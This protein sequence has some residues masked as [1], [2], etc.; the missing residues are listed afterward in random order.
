MRGHDTTREGKARRTD[1]MTARRAL[2]IQSDCGEL[3]KSMKSRI[4]FLFCWI[5]AACL[6][7]WSQDKLYPVRDNKDVSVLI[8]SDRLSFVVERA[9]QHR[10]TFGFPDDD[11]LSVLPN[12]RSTILVFWMKIQN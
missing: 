10:L 4:G 1:S 8:S 7:I 6:P 3:P 9:F 11:E 2:T 5:F 12:T